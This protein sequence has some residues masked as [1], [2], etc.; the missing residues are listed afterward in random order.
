MSVGQIGHFYVHPLWLKKNG[1]A[2]IFL[3]SFDQQILWSYLSGSM[4]DY[5]NIVFLVKDEDDTIDYK[6]VN[7]EMTYLTNFYK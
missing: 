6:W 3:D 1:I 5:D 2:F 7:V 4:R